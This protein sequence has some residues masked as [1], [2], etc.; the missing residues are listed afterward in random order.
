M[1]VQDRPRGCKRGRGRAYGRSKTM[2]MSV[3]RGTHRPRRDR[4]RQ[5]LRETGCF[6]YDPGFTS[7]ANCARESPISTATRANCSIAATRSTSS[8]ST[9][10][11]SR[12]ATCCSTASCRRRQQ[13]DKFRNTITHHT[14]VHE[15]MA[16]FFTGFRRDAHPMAVMV[17]VSRRALGVL[18]RLHRHQRSGAARGRKPPH[19]R[20]DADDRGNGLQVFDRPALHLSAQRSRLHVELPADVLRGSVRALYRQSRSSRARSTASSSCTPTTSRMPRPRPCALR[21]RPAP[22]LSRASRPASPAFGGPRTAAP[23]RPRST[24]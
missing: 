23:T 14:M 21:A 7:T 8:P 5:A 16:R 24:C 18:S 6:T 2:K 15:Q 22:T 11:S 19:D 3:R 1:N 4:R 17:G 9:R 12:S 20:Q 13:F 10:T